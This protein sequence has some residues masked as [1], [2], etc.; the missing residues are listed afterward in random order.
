MSFIPKI[1][2]AF[3]FLEEEH[4]RFSHLGWDS[5]KDVLKSKRECIKLIFSLVKK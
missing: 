1:E 2:Q 5:L 3:S 4:K